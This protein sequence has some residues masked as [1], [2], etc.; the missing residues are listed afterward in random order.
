MRS[1]LRWKKRKSISDERVM[2]R[3]IAYFNQNFF[4]STANNTLTWSRWY[5]P[6]INSADGLHEIDC[7]LQYC[8]RVLSTG[9]HVK[10]NYRVTYEQLKA[11]GYKSLV[12]EYY[13]YKESRQ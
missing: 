2:L 1:L 3:M 10:S 12:H 5:F 4:E 9:R 11:L 8:I 6:V 7:Y 13:K